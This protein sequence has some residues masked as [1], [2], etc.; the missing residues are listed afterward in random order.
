[1][2]SHENPKAT[3]R[4]RVEFSMTRVDAVYISIDTPLY[5]QPDNA[6]SRKQS[7]TRSKCS[8]PPPITRHH[9]SRIKHFERRKK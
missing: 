8:A 6:S 1:M 7:S 4:R 9:P 2:P 3:Q 5:E